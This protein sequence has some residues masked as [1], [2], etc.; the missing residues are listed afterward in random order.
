[1]ATYY[2]KYY[3]KDSV[4]MAASSVLPVF[5]S[6]LIDFATQNVTTSDTVNML[7]IPAQTLVMHCN[8]QTVTT[9]TDATSQFVIASNTAAISY[10]TTAVAVAAGSYGAP[11]TISASTAQK[12]Y[13]AKDDIQLKTVTVANL[14]V[15]QIRVF[16]IMLYP[17]PTNYVDVD[18]NTKT[19]TFTDRNSW[20]TTAPVIP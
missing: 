7:A 4:G 13:S 5:H 2:P 6:R 19:Y 16:A 1:M 20:T 11:A 15:G 10:V 12:F 17:Q 14:T 9:V 8:Y 3:Y 18:G